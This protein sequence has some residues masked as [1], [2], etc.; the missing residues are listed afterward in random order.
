MP[1]LKDFVGMPHTEQYRHLYQFAHILCEELDIPVPRIE[2]GIN[3]WGSHFNQDHYLVFLNTYQ[4]DS[5]RAS[6]LMVLAHEIRHAWQYKVGMLTRQLRQAPRMGIAEELIVWQ[7]EIV[8]YRGLKHHQL[9]W[10]QDAIEFEEMIAAMIQVKPYPR[11]ERDMERRMKAQME[12]AR[13]LQDYF[14][15]IQQSA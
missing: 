15:H 9:P 6:P 13:R 12:V 8:D 14:E 7:G 1:N 10:E 2:A 11:P 4:L 3:F 5:E